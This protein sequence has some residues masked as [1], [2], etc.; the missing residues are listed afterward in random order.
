MKFNIKLKSAEEL[1]SFKVNSA[2]VLFADQNKKSAETALLL[3][4]AFGVETNKYFLEKISDKEIKQFTVAFSQ[5]KPDVLFLRKFNVKEKF[6]SDFF[7]NNL[8]GLIQN[9][10]NEKIKNLSIVIPEFKTF[11]KLFVGEKYFLQTFIEGIFLGNYTFDKY[12]SKKNKHTALNIDLVYKD[13]KL[14]NAVIKETEMLMTSV[15]FARDLVNEPANSLTPEELFKRSKKELSKFGVKVTAI[16]ENELRRRKMNAILAVGGASA[17]PPKLIVIEY[18]P[19]Q[20][21]K[22][23]IALVGKGVTY[24]SGGL[25]I[26]PTAGMLEMKADM[27]GSATVIGTI[28]AAAKASLPVHLLGFIPAVE[29][30]VS[31]ASYKPGDVITSYSG[32]TIEVKDTDAEGRIVLSDA[33]TFASEKKPEMIIDFATL[34]GAVAVAL[35]LFTAGVF[36]KDDKLADGI[37]SSGA[38]TFE[39]LWRLPFW[40]DFNDLLKSDIADVSN[41]GPRWGGAITAGKF[42]ERFV[43]EK[44]PYAHIDLAG[45]AI[46]H[47]FNNYTKKYM[48]GYGVRLMYDFLSNVA[49]N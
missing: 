13:A 8:A 43:D 2:L 5:G 48:T 15:Y 39:R 25:S 44:I 19:K 42:L 34:T 35:G 40:D 21:S 11:E 27:G 49:K 22:K 16:N 10:G 1:K 4:N 23:K 33:L 28:L 12:L 24:D 30:M 29:N 41:L 36:T 31:G 32:K 26:K 6:N 37:L 45:P 17:N 7:R 20:R 14:L 46:N 3:K 9:L 47:E 18:K 38:T